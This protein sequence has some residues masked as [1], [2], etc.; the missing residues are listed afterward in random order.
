MRSRSADSGL[1]NWCEA[2]ATK[3]RCCSST[4]STLS[5]ISLNDRAR[6]RSSGGPP[7]AA[8]PG[9]H[10]AGGDVVGDPVQGLDRAAAPSRSAGRRAAPRSPWRPVRRAASSSQPCRMR[11]RSAPVGES[12]TTTATTS[13]SRTMGEAMASMRCCQGHTCGGLWARPAEQRRLV[14]VVDLAAGGTRQPRGRGGHGGAVTVEDAGPDAVELLVAGEF[15]AQ[16]VQALVVAPG[17]RRFARR[18]AVTNWRQGG[19]PGRCRRYGR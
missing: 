16:G 3:A 11:E 6:R 14:G 1:R 7:A 8:D 9:V 2:S 4:A 13:P 12:V 17:R 19:E 5:A 15:G 10:P 18:R